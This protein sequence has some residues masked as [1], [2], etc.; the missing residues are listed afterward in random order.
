MPPPGG[1]EVARQHRDHLG[2]L[3]R[4]A[5]RLAQ[6]LEILLVGGTPGVAFLGLKESPSDALVKIAQAT[7]RWMPMERQ[8]FGLDH[9]QEVDKPVPVTL[10]I[11]WSKLFE[12]AG[13]AAPIDGGP[14]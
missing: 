8:A 12:Q 5:T 13:I 11:D 7:A 1:V 9:R 14:G 4:I 3:Q 10:G 2:C 6:Q